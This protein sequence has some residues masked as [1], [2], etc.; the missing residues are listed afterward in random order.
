MT[1]PRPVGL[2]EKRSYD[3]MFYSPPDMNKAFTAGFKNRRW[4]ERRNTFWLTADAKLL[5]EIYG[6]TAEQQRKAI[7]ESASNPEFDAA[8][9]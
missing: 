9:L 7:K 6:L 5:R 1:A 4:A 3:K 2:K 8:F